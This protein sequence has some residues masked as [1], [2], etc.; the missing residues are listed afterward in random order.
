MGMKSRVALGGLYARAI[1]ATNAYYTN[2]TKNRYWPSTTWRL[3]PC[4][5][6]QL[7]FK[8]QEWSISNVIGKKMRWPVFNA[9]PFSYPM[10]PWN[11]IY[12][13]STFFHLFA[14]S[15]EPDGAANPPESGWAGVHL[16]SFKDSLR[17]C[18]FTFCRLTRATRHPMVTCAS[19]PPD[20]CFP[21]IGS[22]MF[23][24]K[25]TGNP[26]NKHPKNY[27]F[28]QVFSLKPYVHY[29]S[30]MFVFPLCRDSRSWR[31]AINVNALAFQD[32]PWNKW[33]TIFL[34]WCCS[35]N[36]WLRTMVV[37]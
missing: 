6:C 18:H 34:T 14:F 24:G 10:L 7:I 11:M 22:R 4:F 36:S 21:R 27:E 32:G 20:G 29:Y 13:G 5:W 37:R 31:K 35:L 33:L 8:I 28:L 26:W 23:K 9:D 19:R 3:T 1:E 16:P 12:E 15:G 30:L 2:A 25:P 17:N